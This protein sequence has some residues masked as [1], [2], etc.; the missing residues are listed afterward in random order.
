MRDN[1]SKGITD[2]RAT[3][4]SRGSEASRWPLER[5]V[6]RGYAVATAYYGD[7][8]PDFDDGFQNGVHPLF[9][10]PGQTGPPPTSG[11]RSAPGPGG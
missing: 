6:E 10:R 8:D 4:Q 9:Y 1:P 11:A 3:E 5:I 7:I 2:N